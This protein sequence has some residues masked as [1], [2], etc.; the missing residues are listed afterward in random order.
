MADL[1]VYVCGDLFRFVV[2]AMFCL[3]FYMLLPLYSFYLYGFCVFVLIVLI[4]SFLNVLGMVVLS[5][6]IL[7]LIRLKRVMLLGIRFNW[8]LNLIW[9]G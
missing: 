4:F 9:R 5:V 7:V 3:H 1:C 2:I 8:M 6:F